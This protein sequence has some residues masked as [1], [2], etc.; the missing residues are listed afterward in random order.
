MKIVKL[1]ICVT[2]RCN[3][4]CKNCLR[5]CNLKDITG[6]DYSDS[7]M[8][9][10][11][12]DY[13]IDQMRALKGQF[14]LRSLNLSGGEPLLHPQIV[15]IVER[16]EVLRREGLVRSLTVNSN[17]VVTAPECLKTYII[18]YVKLKEQITKTSGSSS[19]SWLF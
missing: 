4:Y 8:T 3:A 7:D 1:D 19:A 9:M 6:L 18:N 13:F 11:Q 17:E 10:G 2:L 12:I 5:F 15:E 14:M 16:L